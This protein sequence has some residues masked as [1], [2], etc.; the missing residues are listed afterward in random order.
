MVLH[1]CPC[2]RTFD[3]KDNFITHQKTCRAHAKIRDLEAQLEEAKRHIRELT[4]ALVRNGSDVVSKEEHLLVQ[5]DQML[6]EKDLQI[7][8][9][10]EQLTAALRQA[11]PKQ[12]SNTY[13]VTV[14]VF[15]NECMAHIDPASVLELVKDPPTSVPR[16]I[17]M[18]HAEP[19]NATIRCTNIR[20]GHYLLSSGDRFVP[21][22]KES[23]HRRLYLTNQSR[24]LDVATGRMREMEAR[25]AA[26]K[27]A[28]EAEEEEEKVREEEEREERRRAVE[29]ARL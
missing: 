26:G 3:R 18:L 25:A 29:E 13:N 20:E 5:K 24:M 28:L 16:F 7:W 17:K 4:D 1:Q 12:V 15:G 22:S 14:N 23:V 27:A 6:R 9:L 19:T 10:N 2:T 21:E 8:T 11:R